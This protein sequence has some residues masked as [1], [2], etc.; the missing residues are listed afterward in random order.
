MINNKKSNK[1]KNQLD[2]LGCSDCKFNPG[3]PGWPECGHPQGPRF[4][5]G[6]RC[7][8]RNNKNIV[9]KKRLL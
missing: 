4:R 7:V 8:R 1:Y 9:S 6:D 5:Y 3:K 2:W